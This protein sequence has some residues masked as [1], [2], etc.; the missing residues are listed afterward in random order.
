LQRLVDKKIFGNKMG[1]EKF[2][3]TNNTYR[4]KYTTAFK[5]SYDGIIYVE[6]HL[7]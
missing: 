3:K 2:H 1:R 5:P 4:S 7:M 6:S